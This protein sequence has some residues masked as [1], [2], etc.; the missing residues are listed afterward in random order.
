[1]NDIKVDDKIKEAGLN[2][3]PDFYTSLT[4]NPIADIADHRRVDR[5]FISLKEIRRVSTTIP[6]AP[7]LSVPMIITLTESHNLKGQAWGFVYSGGIE[8]VTLI[9]GVGS[10]D[11]NLYIEL[12][13][14]NT[15]PQAISFNLHINELTIKR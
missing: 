8:G 4:D 7:S 15:T 9:N 12:E 1:M 6:A 2:E 5:A 14:Y 10:D 3:V 11:Q 13:N